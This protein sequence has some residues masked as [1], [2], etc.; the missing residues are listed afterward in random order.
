MRLTFRTVLA[1]VVLLVV[2]AVVVGGFL[3]VGSPAEAR[4]RRLD[5]RRV[6]DLRRLVGAVNLYWTRKHA[7]PDSIDAAIT[8][9]SWD[10][11]PVDPGTSQPYEYRVIKAAE[12]ELCASFD[13]ASQGGLPTVR[14]DPFW[15]HPAGRQ[16]YTMKARDERKDPGR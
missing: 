16:C 10:V 3:V 5:D 7:L 9:G 14:D 6:S 13:R 4:L 11:R 8:E 2:A 12:F 1:G 15:S